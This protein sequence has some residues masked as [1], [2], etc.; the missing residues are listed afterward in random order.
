[1]FKRFSFLR[2]YFKLC[3]HFLQIFLFQLRKCFWILLILGFGR[4]LLYVILAFL[5]SHSFFTKTQFLTTPWCS[6]S[7]YH[8]TPLG[9]DWIQVLRKFKSCSRRVGDMWW[10]EKTK[11][12]TSKLKHLYHCQDLVVN[13]FILKIIDLKLDLS[14]CVKS[15]AAIQRC[16]WEKMFWKYAAHLRENTHDE[17]R[18][19]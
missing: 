17:A 13:Y 14:F 12:Y 10:Q 6:G 9:R 18:L 7:Q 1:M 11:R 2:A 8:T 3:Q 4:A 5:V 19:Q 15:E 16:S